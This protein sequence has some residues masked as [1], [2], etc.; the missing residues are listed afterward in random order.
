MNK[1]ILVDSDGLVYHSE[2]DTLQESLSA[3]ED[4][5]QNMFEKTEAT[6]YV[7]FISNGKYFRHN[8]DPC[9]KQSREK[10]RSKVK[11]CKVLKQYL[12]AQYN[13]Q[14]ME[15]VEADDLVSYWMNNP[16]YYGKFINPHSDSHWMF[17]THEL[18]RIADEYQQ[19]E[20][21]ICSPDK[22]LLQNIEGK[23]FNYS[24]KLEDK[25][26]LNSIIKGWWVET[27]IYDAKLNF[28]KSMICG[29]AADRIV[30]LKGKGEKYFE[31]LYVDKEC[32]KLGREE[33]NLRDYELQILFEY[34]QH[35]NP[36]NIVTQAQGIYEFQKNYR[37]LHMLNCDED[38]IREVGKLP[39]FPVI[40]E[41]N[42]QNVEQII[43]EF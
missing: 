19:V 9:Y 28:W 3:L 31:N 2:R 42:K 18:V 39:E 30:G 5:I 13:A 7:F 8:I 10:Y 21:I 12:I 20:K 33:Y 16:I 34:I 17:C 25:N 41:I 37:L 32:F 15:N 43:P 6:H 27:N 4:K 11:W 24:Y 40:S 1:L 35:Y 23:H 26:D 22:D 36:E 14:Y 29:D 38:F